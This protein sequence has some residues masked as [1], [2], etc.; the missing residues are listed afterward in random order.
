MHGRRRRKQEKIPVLYWFFRN[1]CVSPS[2]SR[3]FRMQSQWSFISVQCW[4]SERILPIYLWYWM[5][6]QSSFYH[7]L[8]INTWRSKF[9]Q[10]TDSIYS[11]CLLIL[12]TKVT[13]I[14]KRLTWMY[15]VERDTCTVHGRNIKTRYI[16]STPILRLRKDW[17]SIRHDRMQSSFKEYF[18]L[19]VFQKLLDWRLEKSYMKKHT[20]HL[21]LHQRSHYVTIGQRSWVRKL[22]ISQLDR[23]Y[24]SCLLIDPKVIDLNVPRHA[25]YLHT[26]WVDINLAIQKGLT[27]YQTRSNAIILQGTLPAYLLYS[28]SC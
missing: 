22:N 4:Y 16:G 14:L 28:E 1:N 13:R 24:F 15:H 5:C 21:D 12:G 27:F 6:V 18:Q 2:S 17:H 11:F 25:Q 10:T 26:A 3:T 20:C 19:I 9:E 23:Q 8:W 7:Q